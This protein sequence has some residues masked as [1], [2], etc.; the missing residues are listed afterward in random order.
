MCDGGRVLAGGPLPLCALRSPI[1]AQPLSPLLQLIPVIV[2][3]WTRERPSPRTATSVQTGRRCVSMVGHAG[4]QP[5]GREPAAP[6][7]LAGSLRELSFLVVSNCRCCAPLRLTGCVC[8]SVRLTA[9]PTPAGDDCKGR[10]RLETHV[11]TRSQLSRPGGL[12]GTLGLALSRAGRPAL[13]SWFC[14]VFT[15]A[16]CLL[17]LC[18]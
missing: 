7:V 8:P 13:L 10:K 5:S 15:N 2:G 3:G 14:R 1:P 18:A 4:P 16:P 12:A 9:C 11:T 6:A 17:F